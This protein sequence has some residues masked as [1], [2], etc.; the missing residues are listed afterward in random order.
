MFVENILLDCLQNNRI[1]KE[2]IQR[3]LEGAPGSR[4]KKTPEISK[5][6]VVAP[7]SLRD[8]REIDDAPDVPSAIPVAANTLAA[9]PASNVVIGQDRVEPIRGIRK[10]M[11]KS[12]TAAL[13]VTRLF[14]YLAYFSSR[15]FQIPH[16]GYS[17]EVDDLSESQ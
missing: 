10:A 3:F 11:V 14:F 13:K 7:S 4:A 8:A 17:D 12:M 2:D 9:V 1:L 15:H 6:A 16:F 5:P